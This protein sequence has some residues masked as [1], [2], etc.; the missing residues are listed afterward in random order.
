MLNPG[1]EEH[2]RA[3]QRKSNFVQEGEETGRG[4]GVSAI[5]AEFLCDLGGQKRNFAA[6]LHRRVPCGIP[7]RRKHSESR[8]RP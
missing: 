5:S 7:D 4:S 8:V 3:K 1:S 6:D 2:L